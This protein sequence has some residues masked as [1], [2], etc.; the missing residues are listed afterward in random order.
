MLLQQGPT[1]RDTGRKMRLAL[2]FWENKIS[3]VLD[4]AARLLVVEVDV[5]ENELLP[6][7][8]ALEAVVQEIVQRTSHPEK[9]KKQAQ[10]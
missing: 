3:P 4:S 10:A 2:P 6:F 9:N 7:A 8:M 1:S 5:L